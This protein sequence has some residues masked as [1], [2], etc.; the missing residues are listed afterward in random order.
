M[1]ASGAIVRTT[2]SL[3]LP[4]SSSWRRKSRNSSLTGFL[5]RSAPLEVLKENLDFP[6]LGRKEAASWLP[7]KVI[8]L[9]LRNTVRILIVQ[10]PTSCL[11]VLPQ[12]TKEHPVT[13]YN[14]LPDLNACVDKF[15][16]KRPSTRS[17]RG[18]NLRE[19]S[20]I[21]IKS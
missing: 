4:D 8:N 6:T 18:I 3:P 7:K 11:F 2:Y 19:K 10:F 14:S 16:G 15:P 12:Y 5:F 20:I 1:I 21:N 13:V 9:G 17:L